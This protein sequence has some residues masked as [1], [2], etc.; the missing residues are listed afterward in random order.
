MV[1]MV[2]CVQVQLLSPV[3]PLSPES[4]FRREF[5]PPQAGSV[6]ALCLVT[7]VSPALT[8]VLPLEGPLLASCLKHDPPR[9]APHSSCFSEHLAVGTFF[10]PKE[11]D[12]SL[13]HPPPPS[14]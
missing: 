6:R 2:L 11:M 4:C 14:K 3:F 7:P 12:L 9:P 10:S 13:D 8:L 5:I 1:S